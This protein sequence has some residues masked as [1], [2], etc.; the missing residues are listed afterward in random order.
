MSGQT[1]PTENRSRSNSVDLSGNP[2]SP[3]RKKFLNGWAKEQE[4]LMA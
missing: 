4:N 3:A 2:T 1:T